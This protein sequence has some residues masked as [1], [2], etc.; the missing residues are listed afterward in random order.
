MYTEE[1]P[2][3]SRLEMTLEEDYRVDT[4]QTSAVVDFYRGTYKNISLLARMKIRLLII[5][6]L[7]SPIFRAVKLGVESKA[8]R[9]QKF[10]NNPLGL[11]EMLAEKEQETETF[12]EMS[13]SDQLL[14]GILILAGV[15]HCD[16]KH[17]A[18]R[19]VYKNFRYRYEFSSAIAFAGP[20]FFVLIFVL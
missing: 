18:N 6:D 9:D 5:L 17:G 8:F 7:V 2:T 16:S 11:E 15:L 20:I 19:A 4:T 10:I 3:K 13:N 1:Y 12:D 14:T